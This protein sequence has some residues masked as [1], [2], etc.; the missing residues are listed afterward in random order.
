[1]RPEG[2]SLYLFTF[3]PSHLH[4]SKYFLYLFS[5]PL[6]G[7]AGECGAHVGR[8]WGACGDGWAALVVYEG[9]VAADVRVKIW[10]D[11]VKV[12]VDF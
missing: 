6:P 7:P 10:A 5:N 3:S 8:M 12:C 4:F 1:M 9:A 2:F 11:G